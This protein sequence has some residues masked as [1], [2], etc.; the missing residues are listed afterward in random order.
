MEENA[1]KWVKRIAIVLA[2]LLIV[3]I[4]ALLVLGHRPNAGIMQAS[5]EMNAPPDRLWT[6]LDDGDKLKQWVSWM[7]DVKYPDPQKT[8]GLGAKR[9]WTMKDENNGG[10]LMQIAATY[11]EYAPPSRM[12]LQIADAEGMYQGEASYRLVDLGSG[13]T[14]VEVREHGHYTE[15]MA[16]LMEPLITPAAEKKMVM[17]VARLKQLVE[18]K[19]E[20]R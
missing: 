12:T 1:M 6:W 16:S 20:V 4:A 15:W 9:V 13:R 19:A 7:V 11:T 17:D 10:A 5:L 18:T 8:H 14:R 3:P 2:V